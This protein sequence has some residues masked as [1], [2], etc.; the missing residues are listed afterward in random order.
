V[1]A[2]A[3]SPAAVR[4][5]LMLTQPVAEPEIAV[6]LGPRSRAVATLQLWQLTHR[7]GCGLLAGRKKS[8][9]P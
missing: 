5:P 1:L 8:S 4:D 2:K 3:F 7:P 9:A 6:L